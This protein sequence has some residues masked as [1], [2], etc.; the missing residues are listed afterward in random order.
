MHYALSNAG[1]T[2]KPEQ[3]PA[4][5]DKRNTD[6]AAVIGSVFNH[7]RLEQ[8]VS[9]AELANR[10]ELSRRTLIKIEQG[11]DSVAFRSYRKVA[12][13]LNLT[14]LLEGFGASASGF[15]F[16]TPKYY[17]SGATALS[18]PIPTMGAPALWYSSSLSST[19]TWRIAGV[20]MTSTSD[21]LGV[22][23]LW[24]ATKVIARY[25][26]HLPHIW[27]ASPERAVFD[28]LIQHG[29]V[30]RR[31]IPNIQVSDI[32]DVV[33]MEEVRGMLAHCRPFLSEHGHQLI[34]A[35]LKGGY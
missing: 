6:N 30:E 15:D 28:L 17:L 23:G 16:P 12:E 10:T 22:T 35:W 13:A 32:D 20:N 9:G 18:I 7:A 3:I 4:P 21:L 25:G 8:R 31:P 29:E 5:T 11:D 2:M 33:S 26:V 1:T 24:D 34:Q 14:T 27:A 19:K